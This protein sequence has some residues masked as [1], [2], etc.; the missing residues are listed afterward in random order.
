MQ[1]KINYFQKMQKN[2]YFWTMEII[3]FW[4]AAKRELLFIFWFVGRIAPHT[5]PPNKF[6]EKLYGNSDAGRD[7]TKVYFG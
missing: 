7:Y 3:I 6:Q 5:R 4:E 1:K 2:N